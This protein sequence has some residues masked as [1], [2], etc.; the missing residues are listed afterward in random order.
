MDGEY[1]CTDNRQYK[2]LLLKIESAFLF[3]L[4]NKFGKCDT[5]EFE[6]FLM[7]LSFLIKVYASYF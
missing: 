6:L 7:A 4:K 1:I 2:I 3:F 5:F